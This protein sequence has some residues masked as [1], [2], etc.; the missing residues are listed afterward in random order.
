VGN[1]AEVKARPAWARNA[2]L[3]HIRHEAGSAFD[4]DVVRAFVEMIQDTEPAA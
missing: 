4:P 1:L 3:A 2:A